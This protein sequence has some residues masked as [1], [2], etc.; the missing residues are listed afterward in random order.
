MSFIPLRSLLLGTAI[1]TIG[2]GASAENAWLAA[3][4]H[5]EGSLRAGS[6]EAPVKPGDE[7]QLLLRNLTPGALIEVLRGS[8]LLTETAVTV[9]ED[10]TVSIPIAVPVDAEVG[11]QPL[12]V[13][14]QNPSGVALVNL[15]LSNVIPPSNESAYELTPAKIGERAY[16]AAVAAD[17]RIFVASARGKTEES[18]LVRLS[19]DTME[20][21]A[22][23]TLPAAADGKDGVI[24][25]F[26]VGVD[27]AH[28]R[29]WTANTLNETVTVYDADDLSVVKVFEEGSIRHPHDVVIDQANNR[30]YVNAALTGNIEVYD[31]ET[32]EHVDTL[33]IEAE[34]GASLFATV[35]L[36]L[37]AAAG[38]IYSVSRETP[39]AGWVDLKTGKS[40]TFEVP[41]IDGASGIAH[42]PETGRMYI[43]SQDSNNLVVLDDKGEVLADTEI[44]AGALSVAWDPASKQVYA[45]SRAAGT[46]TVLDADGA[47]VAN[48]PLG[49]LPNHVTVGPD[50]SVYAVAMFGAVDDGDQSGSVTRITAND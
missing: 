43:A 18:G 44:G 41:Q 9:G 46:V 21:E 4:D 28:G 17:G 34:R 30:A 22:S 11:N 26:G 31:T 15:K 24:D 2:S 14:S 25:V 7:T 16:Q 5:I 32:L 12:T 49:D 6:R 8:A 27:D 48:L 1:V 23:A 35:A 45:A 47:I 38:R 37:D 36:D 3:P 50:G 20:I 39:F 13:V 42:D 33:H 10:G 19:P 29:V 40:T